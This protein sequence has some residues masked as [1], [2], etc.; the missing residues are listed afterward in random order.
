MSK[1]YTPSDIE[2]LLHYNCSVIPH[3]RVHAP[4]VKDAIEHYLSRGIIEV[5][6]L[7]GSGYK[8]TS[9]GEA[10][11]HMIC[12]TPL[13]KQFSVWKDPRTDEVIE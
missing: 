8:L 4:A 12:S 13:P 11:L 7:R 9:R 3:P 10:W 5:D 2:V 6:P 1:L